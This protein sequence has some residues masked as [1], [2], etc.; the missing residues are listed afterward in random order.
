MPNDRMD[1]SVGEREVVDDGANGGGVLEVMRCLDSVPTLT[2]GRA[3][4]I[5][6]PDED[7]DGVDVRLVSPVSLI[8]VR[9]CGG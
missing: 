4:E 5:R 7:D 6:A 2:R 9:G 8:S 3:R 1:K